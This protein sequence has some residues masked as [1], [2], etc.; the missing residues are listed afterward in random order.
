V[1][2]GVLFYIGSGFVRALNPATGQRLWHDALIGGIHWESPIV[3]N[4]NLYFTDEN[5]NLTA[6]DL[7]HRR[8]K[9]PKD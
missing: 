8:N 9:F 1:A 6:Y 3:A 2:N 7:T 5:A 4:G